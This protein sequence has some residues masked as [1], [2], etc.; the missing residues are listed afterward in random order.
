MSVIKPIFT[1]SSAARAL[2]AVSAIPAAAAKQSEV[3]RARVFLFICVSPSF[4]VVFIRGNVR[5]ESGRREMARSKR[6][7]RSHPEQVMQDRHFAFELL[8]AEMLDDA[9]VLHHIEAVR[10]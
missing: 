1:A 5:C 7:R 9:A 8:G 4:C 6:P 2:P 3:R 10:E